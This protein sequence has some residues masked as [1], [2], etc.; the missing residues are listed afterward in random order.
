LKQGCHYRITASLAVPSDPK[1]GTLLRGRYVSPETLIQIVQPAEVID[2]LL[3]N[4]FQI[5]NVI[6]A[7]IVL[8]GIATMLAIVLV[9]ALS[10]RL[11]QREIDTVFK[12]GCR[13]MTIARLM[14]A[15]IFIII[16]FSSFLCVG[17]MTVVE[18]FKHDLVRMAFI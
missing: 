8:V 2:G 17:L 13:R 14:A 11:R 12:L 7:I 4:I 16:V 5:K 3:Q 18:Y 6:D 10:L 9:F 15:E 1:S